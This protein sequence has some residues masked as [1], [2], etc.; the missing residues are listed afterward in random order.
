M[1]KKDGIT[2]TAEIRALEASGK[3]QRKH[4]IVALTAVVNTESR[5]KFKEAGADDFLAKPLS[6]TGL[7]DA[8]AVHLA[9]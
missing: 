3:L 7:K 6:L 5:A 9:C 4:I 1:P 8:L 2:A